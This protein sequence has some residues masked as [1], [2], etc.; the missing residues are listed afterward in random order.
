MRAALGALKIR[1]AR[2]LSLESLG[3]NPFHWFYSDIGNMRTRILRSIGVPIVCA[4]FAGCG[5]GDDGSPQEY[6]SQAIEVVVP[7]EPGGGDRHVHSHTCPGDSGAESV[8]AATGEPPD[9]RG[10][11]T[12]D[13][14]Y[15]PPGSVPASSLFSLHLAAQVEDLE[16]T[17]AKV[18][19]KAVKSLADKKGGNTAVVCQ[20]LGGVVKDPAPDVRDEA[21]IALIKVGGQDC[22]PGLR[23]ATKDVDPDIQALAADGI[24]NFY[25]PGYVKFG[26]LNS[27]KGFGKAV[28]N[29]FSDPEPL[30][31][32]PSVR[33]MDADAQ[34]I[35]PL[36]GGGSSMDS[37]ANAARAAG[38]LRASAAVPELKKALNSEDETIQIEAIR[39]LEKIG[40]PSAGPEIAKLLNRR[41][42]KVQI[43]AAEAVGQ[44]RTKEAVSDLAR[45]SKTSKDK[46]VQRAA[47]VALAKIPDNGED[48]TFLLYMQDKDEQMRAAAAEGLGRAG[49]QGD[50][51]TIQDAFATEKNES[52]RQSLA[53]ASVLLGDMDK[54]QYVVDG[55]DSTFHRGEARAFLI[56]L[57]RNPR[58]LNE[59]YTPLTSG[60]RDQKIEL[61]RVIARSGTRESVSHLQKVAGDSD[62]RVAEA[63]GIALRNLESRL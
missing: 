4:L 13:E 21:V 46:D 18:R 57:A 14:T 45:L 63:A 52:A 22:L 51:K 28:K 49:K 12:H 3:R 19:K 1:S 8:A 5:A 50:L 56:E 36:I 53:F 34:A 39:S 60:T 42:E 11:V 37:R 25:M 16:S 30:I 15:F 24:V 10:L 26:W 47:L 27:V 9:V 55:L 23:T 20:A 48:R 33:V 31:V 32:E 2:A 17:D 58:V 44:L 7:F 35:T 41:E 62:P 61:S 29:R 54:L 38:I 40:D 6:P 59:L 43:A